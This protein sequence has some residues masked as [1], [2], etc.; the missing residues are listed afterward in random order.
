MGKSKLP[1]KLSKELK[2]LENDIGM[3]RIMPKDRAKFN[4][5]IL[6]R[7]KTWTD[8][9]S[10]QSIERTSPN[11]ECSGTVL[12]CWFGIGGVNGQTAQG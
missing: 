5:G 6:L 7:Y 10:S 3:I 11:L 9:C 1:R 2:K 8:K 12:H 4:T